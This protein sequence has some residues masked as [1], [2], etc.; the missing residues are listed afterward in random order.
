MR[1]IWGISFAVACLSGP[2]V[3]QQGS[4]YSTGLRVA[5]ARGYENADCYARVFAKHA[6][7]IEKPGGGRSWLASSTPAYNAEQRSRCR[8]D[9]LQDL[10]ARQEARRSGAMGAPRPSGTAYSAGLRV[11][12][13]RGYSGSDATCLARTF[14]V[15][16]APYPNPNGRPNYAV[17]GANMR[18]YTQE[19][20]R[21]C[22]I[23]R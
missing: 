3:A 9:R 20:F 13:Q 23:S 11:A 18:S 19:L 10:A 14:A 15:F 16:A 21:A 17:E 8:I 12:A 22:Q 2:A 7:I 6:V 4:A 5:Q 1:I